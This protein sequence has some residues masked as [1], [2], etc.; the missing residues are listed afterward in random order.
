MADEK[1]VPAVKAPDHH[2]VVMHP[3]GKYRRG[4]VI[5]DADE[6][7]AVKAGDNHRLAHKI[8]PQ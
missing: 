4:D 8:F 5:T 3:F 1:Q 6:I 2:L 7:E